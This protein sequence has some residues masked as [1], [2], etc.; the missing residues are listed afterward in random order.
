MGECYSTLAVRGRPAAAPDILLLEIISSPAAGD[1]I[2]TCCRRSYP[3]LLQEILRFR[4]SGDGG[5]G[6]WRRGILPPGDAGGPD[7]DPPLHTGYIMPGIPPSS[8]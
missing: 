5:D 8:H 2:L 4:L 7:P 6:K 3:H 1:H